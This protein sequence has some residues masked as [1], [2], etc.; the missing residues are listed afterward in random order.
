MTLTNG[1]GVGTPDENDGKSVSGRA[2][3]DATDNIVV[4]GHIGVHDYLDPTMETA[5]AVAWGGDIEIGTWRDGLLV[6]AAF[7]GGDN[8][9]ALGVGGAPGQF[10]AAQAI[11]SYYHTVDGGRLVGIEPLAR[12]SIADPNGSLNQDGGTLVTPGVMFYLMGK[13]KIGINLDYYVPRTGDSEFSFRVGTFL[14]F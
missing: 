13:N 10:L 7:A 3:V 8:W 12:V 5:H 9:R 6:Q 4:S 11:A 2:S 1:T 14:Y